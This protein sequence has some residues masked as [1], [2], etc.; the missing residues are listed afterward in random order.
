MNINTIINLRGLY[1]QT[2]Y[3]GTKKGQ[4]NC[5]TKGAMLFCPL[6]FALK[7]K[8]ISKELKYI[9]RFPN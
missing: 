7:N 3:Y 2:Q 6:Y 8:E 5:Y 9:D 4:K 1:Q